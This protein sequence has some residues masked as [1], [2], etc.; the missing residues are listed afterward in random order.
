[1][2][3]DI[4]FSLF[5]LDCDYRALA[6]GAKFSTNKANPSTAETPSENRGKVFMSVTPSEDSAGLTGDSVRQRIRQR[7]ARAFA[8][9]KLFERRFEVRDGKVRPGFAH[10]HEFRERAFPQQKIG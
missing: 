7:P 6:R 2:N 5:C 8:M 3:A 1:M 4:S 10:E 9:A